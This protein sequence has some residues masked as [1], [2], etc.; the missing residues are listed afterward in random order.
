MITTT[1]NYFAIVLAGML[2][3]CLLTFGQKNPILINSKTVISEGIDLY[4]KEKYDEAIKKFIQV[5]PADSNYFWS[6]YELSLTYLEKKDNEKAIE[7][8]KNAVEAGSSEVS[9]YNVWGNA[10]DNLKKKNEAIAIYDKGISKFPF[11][12][13]LHFNKGVVYEGNEDTKKAL[14]VYQNILKF[15]P[16]HAS[17]HLRLA[18]MCAQE[19]LLTQAIMN[20][21]IFLILEPSSKRSLSVLSELNKLC[22]GSLTDVGSAKTKNIKQ[23]FEDI[24]LLITNQVALNNK[25]KTPSKFSYPVIKQVYLVMEKLAEIKNQEQDFYSQFYLPTLINIKQTQSFKT[26]ALLLLASSD[27]ESIS[28]QV[29][30]QISK[31]KTLRDECIVFW[32]EQHPFYEINLFGKNQK[33]KKWYHNNFSVEAFGI[34]NEDKKNVGDWIYLS[35]NGAI[36]ILGHF[37]N[38]GLK[39]GEWLSFT[40]SGDTSRITNYNN[41]KFDGYYIIYK[42]GFVKEKGYYK[43]GQLEGEV[44]RYFPDGTISNKYNFI[45]DKENGA[46]IKF[47]PI[48]TTLFE[49]TYEKGQ[50]EGAF[51]EYYSNK[52]L[53]EIGTYKNGK[54]SGNYKTFYEDGQ[55]KKD[56][57]YID[58]IIEGNYK[59]Y[60]RNG[61]LESEGNAAKGSVSGDWKYYYSDSKIKEIDTYDENGKINGEEEWFDHQGKK[62]KQATYQKGDLKRIQYFD[63]KGTIISDSKINKSGSPVTFYNFQRDKTAEGKL[64][65]GENDGEWRYYTTCGQ[66]ESTSMY[67]G[68]LSEGQ[69]VWY[70]KNGKILAKVTYIKDNRDGLY[71]NFYSNEVLQ[72]EGNYLKG[73]KSGI[74]YEYYNDGTLKK[75]SYYIDGDLRGFVYNYSVSGK[76]YTKYKYNNYAVLEGIYRCDT[77]GVVIDSAIFK[78]GTI[79]F[80]LKGCS[81]KKY[82]ESNYICGSAHGHQQSYYPNGKNESTGNNYSEYRNGEWIWYYPNGKISLKGKYFHGEKIGT[83]EYYDF[84]GNPTLKCEYLFGESHG[85]DTWYYSDGKI[86]TQN[87][88]FE[89]KKNNSSFYYANNGDLREVRYY[90]HGKYIGYSYHNKTKKLVDT[91]YTLKGEGEIIAY[92]YNGN[93]SSQYTI[94][95]RVYQGVYKIFYPDGKLQEERIYD[96][97][98]ESGPIK[99]YYP[100][101]KIK[102][103]ANYNNG[104]LHGQV[105]EYNTN[106]TVK[107]KENYKND[108]KQGS[109]EYFNKI[110]K[111]TNAYIYYN[112]EVFSILQ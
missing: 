49:Y 67:K 63:Q 38:Q 65:N 57:N 26:F 68:G 66:L 29:K 48:G 45:N 3:H 28:K 55:V 69:T 112:D 110:G 70:H 80:A 18:K 50:L 99:E 94:K 54:Y 42:N 82:L 15:S 7:I 21:T 12:E 24:D 87:N 92:Y 91:I 84:F 106:G 79:Q 19:G 41:D 93:I 8:S 97:G 36:E 17:T 73:N 109:C 47:Y 30:K 100:N 62:Y 13:L 44:I 78:S 10:L 14:E 20:Y 27:D 9:Q 71:N 108:V 51:K 40:P 34:Q 64:V 58:G 89:D 1:K 6:Q 90:E 37:N 46:E 5:H 31:I 52:T 61:I 59:T 77:N 75:E 103:I 98:A 23:E 60:Y 83:W 53:S 102:R 25:Y 76:L 35:V 39:T 111:R 101:G 85:T 95:N 105:L 56:I 96:F 104:E 32:K 16:L 81:G 22:N 33:L 107:L 43:N 74:W 88:F 4:D 2:F 72:I 86:E 11:N